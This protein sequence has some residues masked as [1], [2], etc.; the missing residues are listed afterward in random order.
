MGGRPR[1]LSEGTGGSRRNPAART[2]CEELARRSLRLSEY[3]G[4]SEHRVSESEPAPAPAPEPVPEPEP[5]PEPSSL[6]ACACLFLLGGD[7]DNRS[8]LSR[9][10]ESGCVVP[11]AVH[12]RPAPA[13]PPPRA[14][15]HSQRPRKRATWSRRGPSGPLPG[16]EGLAPHPRPRRARPA[17]GAAT[18][19]SPPELQERAR[20]G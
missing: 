17:P 20:R 19:R 16:G 14:C 5:E 12:A 6:P 2:G 13:P 8:S 10:A 7:W 18:P 9:P 1:T 15:P 11:E 4:C 3:W